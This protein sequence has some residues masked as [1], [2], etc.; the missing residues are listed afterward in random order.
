MTAM[1]QQNK[2]LEEKWLKLE[3][4]RQNEEKER[5]ERLLKFREEEL[6]RERQHELHLFRMLV[7]FS[8][9]QNNFSWFEQ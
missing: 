1:Q 3:Q 5:E 6:E 2:E 7:N 9:N 4:Q 8:Q